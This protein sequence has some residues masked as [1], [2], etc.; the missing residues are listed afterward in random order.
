MKLK[1]CLL[2]GTH[3]PNHN[4]REYTDTHK[5]TKLKAPFPFQIVGLN[6]WQLIMETDSLILAAHP[7]VY[8]GCPRRNVKYFGRVFLKLNY[9]DITQNT[10]IQS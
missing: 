2:C 7:C 5:S 6:T 10:Y 8:R 9:T 3:D 4:K 1:P